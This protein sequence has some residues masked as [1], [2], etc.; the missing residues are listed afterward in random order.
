MT[1]TVVPPG[2]LVEV[3]GI[4]NRPGYSRKG[5]RSGARFVVAADRYQP[6]DWDGYVWLQS[7]PDSDFESGQY[8]G[9]CKFKA[10][11]NPAGVADPFAGTLL[12]HLTKLGPRAL[13]L[14]T[15]IAARLAKGAAEHGDFE[16]LDRDWNQEALEE[17]LDGLVY[18]TVESMR[19]AGKL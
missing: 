8:Y 3:T 5:V 4:V 14:L 18:R 1:K 16:N 6:N 9:W 11:A 13:A 2:T 17:D 12:G 19:K 10:L 7:A 15:E